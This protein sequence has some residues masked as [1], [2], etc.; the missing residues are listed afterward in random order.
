MKKYLWNLFVACDCLCNAILGGD[1]EETMSSRMGK[2][3]AN[4]SGWFPCQICKLLN[5]IQKDHCVKAIELDRGNNAI[6]AESPTDAA[7]IEVVNKNK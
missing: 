2:Y 7:V 3:V 4:K 1:P 6:F 5:L